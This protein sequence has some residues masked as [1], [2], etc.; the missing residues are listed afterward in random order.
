[1]HIAQAQVERE[2]QSRIL[3]QRQRIE[4]E[5]KKFADF[6]VR[7]VSDE[8]QTSELLRMIETMAAAEGVSLTNLKPAGIQTEGAVRT[9][10]VSVACEGEMEYIVSFMH[11]LENAP[12]LIR[13]N[14]ITLSP[15]SRT[16]PALRRA[17]MMLS[18]K[19][20]L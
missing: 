16:N 7:A 17:E 10:R 19:V 14:A 5:E 15:A 13:I 3:Q 8:T 9:F 11:A 1:A 4:R 20:V 2:V 6:S 18:K 12:E